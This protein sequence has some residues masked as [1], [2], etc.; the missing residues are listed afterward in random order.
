MRPSK[1]VFAF[2]V[3]DDVLMKRVF[4]FAFFLALFSIEVQAQ[5]GFDKPGYRKP[6]DLPMKL[7]GTF[8]ELR[9]DHFHSGIDIRTNGVEGL[10]V[11]AVADGFVSRIAVSPVGF[12]KAVYIDHPS[13][14]H[15]SVYGHLQRFE[16]RI[17]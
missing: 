15:T 5:K 8:G 7:A 3:F 1:P 12:G 11:Y 16:G 13:T 2:F 4:L 17:A 6:V 9:P 14:G 10:P